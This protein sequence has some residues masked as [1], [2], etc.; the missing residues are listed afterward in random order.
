MT[1]PKHKCS[2]EGTR[3]RRLRLKLRLTQEGLAHQV[4]VTTHTIWRLENDPIFNPRLETLRAI[5]KALGV[6]VGYFFS[7]S[8]IT[9]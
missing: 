6:D 2:A 7:S 8:R 1:T 9:R 4:G 3:I 5:A